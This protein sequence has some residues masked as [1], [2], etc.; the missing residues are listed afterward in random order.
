MAAPAPAPVNRATTELP[1]SGYALV[2]DGQ[3]KTEFK[4][5][6]GAVNAARDR[7]G[8]FPMLKQE[9]LVDPLD[10]QAAAHVGLK[11][12]GN[13]DDLARR[14]VR[15]G[16]GA[17]VDD[18]HRLAFINLKGFDVSRFHGKTR[19]CSQDCTDVRGD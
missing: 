3:M 6:D 19:E 1:T 4:T 16:I 14:H 13:L 5:K 15:V 17:G 12:V 10:Q 8:R 7:K 11:A 2:V 9:R 18:L